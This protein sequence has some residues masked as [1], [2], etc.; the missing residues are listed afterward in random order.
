M[1]S[2]TVHLPRWKRG[3]KEDLFNKI[4]SKPSFSERGAE[5][6]LPSSYRIK[7]FCLAF[8]LINPAVVFGSISISGLS[9]PLETNLRLTL[10]L[11]QES[12]SAPEW[13]IR[14]LFD[15]SDQQI[16]TALRAL[17]HYHTQNR[18]TLTFS[19]DCW[20]ADFQ[21]DPGPPVIIETITL[22]ITGEAEQDAAFIKLR[23]KLLDYTGKVLNHADYENMKKRISALAME[24][25]YVQ[26]QF[27]ENKLLVDDTRNRAWIDLVYDAGKRL[28]FGDI[29]VDQDILEPDFVSKLISIKTT[30]PYSA[31]KL[32]ETHNALSASG[33]FEMVDV[34][35]ELEH[36]QQLEVPITLKLYPKKTHHYSFGLGYDTDKGPLLGASYLNRR[37]NRNGH[38]LTSDLDLSPVLS[39]ADLEYSVPLENPLTDFFSFGG[40]L[41]REDTQTYASLSSKLSARIKHA[42]TSGWKQTVY[43][44]SIYER[45]RTD[46]TDSSAWLL[47]HGGSWLRSVAD[48]PIRPTEGYR[49]FFNL[50][51]SYQNPL[52]DINMI[53]ASL[54][55]VW[56]HPS[57]WNGRFIVRAQQGATLVD[58]FDKLPTS[59]RFYAGGM[60][61]IRGY[62]YKELGPKDAQGNVV[63]GRFHSV[64]SLEYEQTVFEDWG[65]A[66]FLDT[67]NAYDRA[68]IQFKT[69]AGLGLRWYSPIGPIRV[70]LAVPL[71]NSDSGFQFH[72]AAGTRL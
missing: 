58:R 48:N 67:G 29:T 2:L 21:V 23:E 49:L 26:G 12:C 59:Y 46:S 15:Q 65:L 56:M 53:Q 69:G 50:A 61:S 66:T 30:E 8:C 9:E 38:F 10:G 37:L 1:P 17:G 4:T 55:T 5:R 14:Q 62:A 47:L 33:Y 24:R 41:K 60:D 18:K 39:T 43:L 20:Q 27:V 34:H 63:G 13:K 72:F 64:L 3:N 16:N 22:N 19:P 6:L 71:G 25:G 68:H 52:S 31:T 32:A 45:F 40:G 57:P 7:S 11:S 54:A 70:D 28:N 36:I 51:G 44:D 35:P 42:Y